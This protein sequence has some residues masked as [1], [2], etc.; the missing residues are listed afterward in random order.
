[1]SVLFASY[2]TVHM[3]AT[4]QN[5]GAG[6]VTCRF[7]VF[8]A[9]LL[10]SRR[11]AAMSESLNKVPAVDIDGHGRFK[12]ILI[13]VHDETSNDSKTIVRGYARASWHGLPTP[14][15][16]F[17]SKWKSVTCNRSSQRYQ[18]SNIGVCLEIHGNSC[19]RGTNCSRI[20]GNL[21]SNEG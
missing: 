20:K 14:H 11:F 19:S 3:I 17:R 12:Y 6:A 5:F 15:A 18:D 1:M 4:I 21:S 2:K 8:K 9:V 16:L 13:N 7:P 10:N